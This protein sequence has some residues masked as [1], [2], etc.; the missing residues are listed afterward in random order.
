MNLQTHTNLPLLFGLA[1]GGFIALSMAVGVAPAIWVAQHNA[2]IPGSTPLTPEQQEGLRVYVAEGCGYC[3]TQQVRPLAGDTLFG[4]PSAPGDY[5]RLV[6]LSALIQVPEILGTERTGPDLSDVAARQPSDV[7]H[8]IHLYQPRAVVNASIMPAFPWLFQLTRAPDSQATR[9]PLPTG[10]APAGMSVVVTARAHALVAYLLSLKQPTIGGPR[11][12]V[13]NN[14]AAGA[15]VYA[16]RCASCH[17]PT[18]AG[19]PG[20]FPPLAGDSVVNGPAAEQL[21]VVLNGLHGRTIKGVGYAA[22]MPAWGAML[23][24]AEIAAVVTYERSSW[25]NHGTPVTA[26][27]VAAARRESTGGGK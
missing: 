9:V 7:W 15:Q 18:G 8:Y 27:N 17:Q 13:A 22:A 4:R 12:A 21:E 6:P 24:D 11:T 2:P 26:Q 3:H 10:F 16:T 25:G 20:A 23:S 19:F 1:A 14:A 5:A